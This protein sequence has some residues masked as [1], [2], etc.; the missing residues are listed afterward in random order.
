MNLIDDLKEMWRKGD[1]LGR[2]LI[3]NTSIF[4]IILVYHITCQLMDIPFPYGQE[5]HLAASAN[6]HW[7]AHRPWSLLTH[8]FTHIEFGHFILNMIV[9]Y[10]S[11]RL[12]RFFFNTK[13]LVAVYLLG[14]IAG[15]ALYFL[16]YNIFPSLNS[17]SYIL[18]ASASVM[19]IVIAVGA[20]EPNYPVKLFG[21]FE[22]KLK[23]LCFILVLTDMVALR[24]GD[25]MGGHVGHLGG[26]LFGFVY[27][28]QMA[29]GK[30]MGFWLERIIERIQSLFS[31]KPRMRVEHNMG[32]PKTDDQFN[33]ERVIKQKRVDQILDKIGKSGYDSLSKEEKDFLFKNSQ[34]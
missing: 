28:T 6:M 30:N 12:F 33:E 3:L 26:A 10:T 16:F 14:G 8:M 15:Y 25:N 5:L 7:M 29:K 1:G 4:L 34:K 17:D 31:R 13:K 2:L 18:G 20:K 21:V 19:A 23:W 9:L 32:R 22:M 11:G 27:A 24:K